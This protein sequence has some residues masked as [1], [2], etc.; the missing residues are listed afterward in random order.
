M[1][2][3][4]ACYTNQNQNQTADR[5]LENQKLSCYLYLLRLRVSFVKGI[6]S[7]KFTE[8]DLERGR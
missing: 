7:T 8:E 4:R 3:Y 5:I 1:K 2:S 6:G